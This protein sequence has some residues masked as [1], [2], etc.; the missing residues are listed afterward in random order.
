MTALPDGNGANG[1]E[2]LRSNDFL[3]DYAVFVCPSSTTSAGE[4]TEKLTY[5]ASGAGQDANAS[6]GF[7]GGMIEGDSNIYGRADSAISADLVGNTAGDVQ[8]GSN[9]GNPNHTGYGNILYQ[10]GHVQGHT[11]N[12]WFTLE[13][14]GL[15]ANMDKYMQ[16]NGITNANGAPQN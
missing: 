13:T 15:V 2:I 6:Y 7:V 16:P 8:V 12:G 1:L 9:N 4:G 14:V 3:T 11:G 10:G 5:A